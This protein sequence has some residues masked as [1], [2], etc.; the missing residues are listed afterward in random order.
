MTT[1]HSNV[2]PAVISIDRI[3]NGIARLLVRWD[4][5]QVSVADP[6]TGT[7]RQEWQYS[8][9]IIRWTLPQKYDSTEAVISYLTGIQSEILDWAKATEV[10][11]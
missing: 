7:T 4:I 5:Q 3:E 11:S 8:E 2:E 9:R 10:N 6:M 1:V